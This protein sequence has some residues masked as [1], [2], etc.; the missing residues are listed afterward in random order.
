MNKDDKINFLCKLTGRCCIHN[1]VILNPLDIFN[2]SNYLEIP[3]KYLFKKKILTY[4]INKSD[5][6]M[7]PMINIGKENICPFLISPNEKE[8]L[9]EIHE[10]RPTVCR[11]FP[12]N[13]NYNTEKFK[14]VKSSQQR[15]KE[16]FDNNES[17]SIDDFIKS[18]D[19]ENRF[20]FQKDYRSFI[21][22][23]IDSGYTI[24]KIKNNELKQ[25][26][27]FKIQTILYETYPPQFNRTDTFPWDD[28]KQEI[29]DIIEF[30][31]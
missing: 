11:I 8:F 29:K 28:I 26:N 24:E 5:Y 23:I 19:L 15:C 3:S 7:D 4:I 27:F 17:L 10:A 21:N 2:I 1:Q 20:I 12:L 22:Y 31:N 18:S 6:W 16:C 9:C 14:F 13:F 30:E 25:M